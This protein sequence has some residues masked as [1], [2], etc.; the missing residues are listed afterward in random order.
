LKEVMEKGASKARASASKTME[1][2]R[3]ATGLKYY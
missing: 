1:L 3:E 2:V